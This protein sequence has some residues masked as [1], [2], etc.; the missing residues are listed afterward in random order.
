[1]IDKQEPATSMMVG[2]LLRLLQRPLL[3]LIKW[4][5]CKYEKFAKQLNLHPKANASYL[6]CLFLSP[7]IF[8]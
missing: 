4:K 3:K 8:L 2:T 5:I 7:L 6:D 1:M